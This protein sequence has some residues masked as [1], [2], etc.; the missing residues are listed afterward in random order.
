MKTTAEIVYE[1]SVRAIEQQVR[2]LDE[3]R[4]RAA[5]ALAASG[6]VTGFLGR[7]AVE[8]GLGAFGVF[9]IAA[10]AASAFC[11]LWVMLPRWYA[12][13]F[14]INAKSLIPY[15]LNEADPEP[16]DTL[17]KYLADAIQDDFESNTRQLTSLY[18]WFT[19]GCVALAAQVGLWLLALGLD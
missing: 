10:F 3:L 13:A 6:I 7:A 12:W 5:V 18:R 4:T 19:W 14:S 17:F 15:F 16:P 11:C 8:R 9:A 1:Q 2:Q